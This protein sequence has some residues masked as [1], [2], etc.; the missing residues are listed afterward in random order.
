MSSTAPMMNDL[1]KDISVEIV[2]KPAKKKHDKSS[3]KYFLIII[4]LFIST[5]YYIY[6]YEF[7]WKNFTGNSF[8][9]QLFKY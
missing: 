1:N 7:I 3:E 6:T 5:V 9:V 2:K 8:I 4:A